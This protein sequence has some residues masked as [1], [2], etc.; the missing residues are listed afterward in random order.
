MINKIIDFLRNL[1]LVFV[2]LFFAAF[3]YFGFTELTP[4]QASFDIKKALETQQQKEQ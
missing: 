4:E 3:L 2:V 1:G